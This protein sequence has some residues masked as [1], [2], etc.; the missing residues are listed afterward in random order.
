MLTVRIY[1]FSYLKSG[2]PRDN[3]LNGGGFVFDCRFISNPAR[4]INLEALTGRDKE[5]IEYLENLPEMSEFIKNVVNIIDQCIKNYLNRGFTDLMI[6]FG[7]TGGKHRSVYAAEKLKSYLELHYNSELKVVLK[8][9][10]LAE[11]S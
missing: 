10:E 3:T 7:C 4:L 6:S 8:H 5:V 11:T 9:N 1:S 2:I